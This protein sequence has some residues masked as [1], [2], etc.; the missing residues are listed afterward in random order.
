MFPSARL[1]QGT[2]YAWKNGLNARYLGTN[3]KPSSQLANV[4]NQGLYSVLYDELISD[5]MRCTYI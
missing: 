2:L 1:I 3:V 5:Q 4:L